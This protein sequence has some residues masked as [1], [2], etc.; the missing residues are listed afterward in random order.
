MPVPFDSN[1]A[2]TPESIW[3]AAWTSS[4]PTLAAP[5]FGDQLLIVVA[6]PDDE[7]LGAGGLIASAAAAGAG[8]TI[9]T[10]SDGEASHPGSHTH[11]RAQLAEIRR[12][13]VTAAV[14]RLHPQAEVRF[15]G[16]PD[17][18]LAAHI[19]EIASRLS[20]YGAKASLIVTTWLGDRHP[21]HVACAEVGARLAKTAGIEHWQFPIWAWHWDTPQ[22]QEL[23]KARLR[24]LCLDETALSAKRDA[25]NAHRSQHTALSS[26]PGDEAILSD[27]T[28]DYFRR[29]YEVFIVGDG[30]PAASGA[31]FD[32]LYEQ[33][34]DPWKLTERFYERRKRELVLASLPRHRFARAFEPGCAIGALTVELAERCDE[35]VA[36]DGARIAIDETIKRISGS[37][38]EAR[39]QV[40]CARIPG[41]W[42]SGDFDLIVLSEVGY[43]CTD[44]QQLKD[45]V[46]DSLS[47]DGVLIA[48]HWRRPA[49]DHP[50]TAEAVHAML[51]RGLRTVV[52][53]REG[54]FL[55]DVW[56][57]D[58]ASVAEAEGIV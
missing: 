57:R 14:S 9:V 23:P 4:A 38:G 45:R 29:R 50:F 47:V 53:H 33:N 2:G 27:S 34:R 37:P 18:H 55:L 49:P 13:E 41:D 44:L 11:T 21:D 19:D 48:C 8:V 39:V 28:L 15:L 32:H 7:T 5:H 25:I 56:T 43:Y 31:Y 24:R 17:S 30:A 6:H 1:V 26:E 46:N 40:R 3:E 16:L 12:A 10:A 51:G 35:L 36:W 42:P 22:S 52:V 58:G 20:G 54:D